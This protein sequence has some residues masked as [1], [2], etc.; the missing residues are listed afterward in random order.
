MNAGCVRE[1][2]MKSGAQHQISKRTE[3]KNHPI[4]RRIAL[5]PI[6]PCTSCATVPPSFSRPPHRR[7]EA[8]RG[9]PSYLTAPISELISSTLCLLIYSSIPRTVSTVAYGL[10]K[11]AVPIE[12]AVAPARINSSASSADA[13]PPIPIIGTFTACAT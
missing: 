1:N 4:F 5:V 9:R 6:F 8:A 3:L 2:G 13:I 7:C 12:T 10:K 11:F